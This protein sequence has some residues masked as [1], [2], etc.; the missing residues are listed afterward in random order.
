MRSIVTCAVSAFACALLL[1]V[2]GICVAQ[3]GPLPP[4]PAAP[5][6]PTN[7]INPIIKPPNP[8]VLTTPRPL[9]NSDVYFKYQYCIA[10]AQTVLSDCLNVGPCDTLPSGKPVKCTPN[11][12]ACEATFSRA[13]QACLRPL[14]LSAPPPA[15][16]PAI[17]K[18]RFVVLT[19][20]YAPPGNASNAGFSQGTTQGT[21]TSIS[22]SFALGVTLEFNA[23]GGF[24]A[25]G[26]LGLSF[27]VT[28]T[29]QN[30]Q[31]FEISTTATQGRQVAS[32]SDAVDHTQDRFILWL[33]PQVTITQTGL[34]TGTYTVSPADGQPMDIIDVSTREL[35]NPSLIPPAKL[36]PQNIGGVVVPGLAGLTAMDFQSALSLDP[37]VGKDPTAAPTDGNRFVLVDRQD[38]EGP[39][40]ASLP[41]VSNSF[42]VDD[43]QTLTQ[44]QSE[45]LAYEA[46]VTA[47]GGVDLAIFGSASL[48]AKTAFTWTQQTSFG[49]S[50]G[51]T[52]QASVS[53]AST[54]VG[55]ANCW[56]DIYEDSLYHTF[57]FVPP[58]LPLCNPPVPGAKMVQPVFALSGTVTR[59]TGQPVA[60]AP[61]IVRFVQG[62]VIRLHTNL[63]GKYLVYSAPPGLVQVAVGNA[64]QNQTIVPGQTAVANFVIP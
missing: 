12:A 19:L 51:H 2:S 50:S 6:R 47:G 18:P 46:D 23:S 31:G 40:Q 13:S 29:T 64:V 3:S 25:Q 60:Q 26:S 48:D 11:R 7:P 14:G 39:D 10:P 54:T 52:H 42:T 45:Q 16:G 38:L 27:G 58:N 1:T 30:S 59:A 4:P 32:V 36:G 15:C 35:L 56:I 20:L 43:S 49:T 8:L 57:M 28:G 53:L 5:S 37:F 62:G 34:G 33:N 9:C 17:L 44:T 41:A 22:N 21:T 55:L 61:V 24:I 63:R